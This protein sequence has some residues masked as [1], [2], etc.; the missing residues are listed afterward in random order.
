MPDDCVQFQTNAD[1]IDPTKDIAGVTSINLSR[2]ASGECDTVVPMAKA[3]AVLKITK[4]VVEKLDGKAVAIVSDLKQ[5]Q[6]NNALVSLFLRNSA[7]VLVLNQQTR[8]LNSQLYNERIV[9]DLTDSAKIQ[10]ESLHSD[11]LVIFDSKP[12]KRSQHPNEIP[13]SDRVHAAA[14]FENALKQW[15]FIKAEASADWNLELL[16]P[17]KLT[18]VPSDIAISR[19]QTPKQIITVSH[20]A[21]D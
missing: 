5:Q 10:A 16:K 11:A 2:F 9:V 21:V 6:K 18:P 8:D 20:F 7:S 13:I 12:E 14:I 4:K 17:T 15:S 3:N 1:V 19:A